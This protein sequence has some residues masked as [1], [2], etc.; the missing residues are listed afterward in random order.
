MM[1]VYPQNYF[2]NLRHTGQV[3]DSERRSG[4][5]R[6]C[7]KAEPFDYIAFK[8]KEQNASRFD[9]CAGSQIGARVARW[10][11]MTVV[12]LLLFLSACAATEKPTT[13][14]PFVPQS[15][16]TFKVGKP[17][18]IDGRTYTPLLPASYK[19]SGI[20]SWYGSEFHDKSTANGEVF[21]KHQLTAAHKT[22][23]LPSVVR[24]TNQRNGKSAILRV[25]D[26]GPFV[27]TRLIDLSE[28]SAK[29]LGFH[30]QGL[31]PV[32]VE[33]LPNE[34]YE[35]ALNAGAR[36]QDIAVWK[37]GPEPTALAA[38]PIIPP[39]PTGEE[40]YLQAGAFQN[41][42][43]AAAMARDL[44]AIPDVSLK[45]KVFEQSDNIPHKVRIGPLD[46]SDVAPLKQV[47]AERG[48]GDLALI[49]P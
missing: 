18:T 3:S 7:Q 23:P 20:S 5:Q 25:N 29:A 2:N 40:L 45:T 15:R 30:G 6:N 19:E 17:Y 46:P 35:V 28:A 27:D 11:G 32:V 34:S 44:M 22:L 21:D 39:Q 16:G 1:T 37:G 14:T 31:A 13:P 42:E 24:V 38:A 4:I 49:T 47:L 48:Y 26:R 9:I 8:N 36:P 41:P 12:C 33:L 10:S 43:A